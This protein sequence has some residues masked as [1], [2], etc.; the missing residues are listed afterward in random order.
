MRKNPVKLMAAGMLVLVLMTGC[1][2]SNRNAGG[3][4][5]NDNSTNENSVNEESDEI[6][7]MDVKN[8]GDNAGEQESQTDAQD[9]QTDDGGQK[10]P[11]AAEYGR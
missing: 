2:L 8:V 5:A 9:G 10:Q 7:S 3:N 4:S 6:L 11:Q 1:G